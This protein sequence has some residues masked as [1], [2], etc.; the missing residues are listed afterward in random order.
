M[1][2]GPS[3]AP[4]SYRRDGAVDAKRHPSRIAAVAVAPRMN[5]YLAKALPA[6]FN[7]SVGCGFGPSGRAMAMWPLTA[8]EPVSKKACERD[9]RDPKRFA[10]HFLPPDG[11]LNIIAEGGPGPEPSLHSVHS[12]ACLFA[13]HVANRPQRRAKLQP[14]F[15]P[16]LVNFFV[17]LLLACT[18]SSKPS[19]YPQHTRASLPHKR[20][21]VRPL[22]KAL[23]GVSSFFARTADASGRGRWQL[24]SLHEAAGHG[25][26]LD[27][28]PEVSA[29]AVKDGRSLSCLSIIVT[30]PLDPAHVKQRGR[31]SRRQGTPVDEGE[32][33]KAAER[34]SPALSWGQGAVDGLLSAAAGEC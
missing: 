28:S 15:G 3:L 27:T 26:S 33:S 4:Q 29:S 12:G 34:P 24:L 19:V 11:S 21:S 20:R 25:C 16:P 6:E 7:W 10:P 1:K 32:H 23:W 17:P 13:G 9:C 30:G 2:T 22:R 31:L 18:A 14:R 8:R 5:G